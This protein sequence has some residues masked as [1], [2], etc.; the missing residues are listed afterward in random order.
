MSPG[1]APVPAPTD[2]AAT[3]GSF[4]GVDV[5]QQSDDD[6]FRSLLI[7]P[8]GVS[9]DLR[10]LLTKAFALVDTDIDDLLPDNFPAVSASVTSCRASSSGII[11]EAVWSG[12]T[13]NAGVLSPFLSGI[14]SGISVKLAA[15]ASV[16]EAEGVLLAFDL[17]LDNKLTLGANI[18]FGSGAAGFNAGWLSNAPNLGTLLRQAG[19]DAIGFGNV[20]IEKIGVSAL[21]TEDLFS[22]EIE[23]ND[24]FALDNHDFKISDA[25]IALNYLRG[26]DGLLTGSA[27][28]TAFLG[29]A[30]QAGQPDDRI[31]F[32]VSASYDGADVGWTFTGTAQNISVGAVLGKFGV[33]SDSPFNDL[34]VD[35]VSLSFNTVSKDVSFS[36]NGS[37][38]PVANAA[39][40]AEVHLTRQPDGSYQKTFSGKLTAGPAEF[41]LIFDQTGSSTALL[42]VF[43]DSTEQ[44]AGINVRDV[45]AAVAPADIAAALPASPAFRIQDALFAFTRG[46]AGQPGKFLFAID[47]DLSLDL[48]GLANL[49]LI[50]QAV[51]GEKLEAAFEVLVYSEQFDPAPIRSLL[52]AGAPQIPNDQLSGKFQFLTT[53]KFGDFTTQLV[54]GPANDLATALA[55]TSS[56]GQP[57]APAVPA[58]ATL[59]A[60]DN[61]KWA[62]IEK[63]FG[64][65]SVHRAGLSFDA[66][67]NQI[68]VFLEADLSVSGLTLSVEGL[69]GIY[70][71][72]TKTLSFALR[73]LGIDFSRGGLEI[74]GG[75]LNQNG[76]FAGKVVIRTQSFTLSALG[77]VAVVDGQPSIFIYGL[78]NYPLG[79]PA[80]FFVEGLAA[81]FGYNRTFRMPTVDQVRSCPLVSDAMAETAVV[82]RA[83][84]PSDKAAVAKQLELLHDFVPPSVGDYFFAAGIKFSSFKLLHSFLLVGIVAGKRFELDLI[85]VSTYENP[86]VAQPGVPALAHIELNL[87][88]RIAPDEGFAIIQGQL[89]DNSY[90]YNSLVKLS[91]GF[92]FATW[93]AEPPGGS[94]LGPH[95]GDF[96]LTI[97]G[98]HPRFAKPDWY[99]TVPRLGITYQINENIYVK[100]T[101]YFA[102]TPSMLMA[103]A[104]LEAHAEIGAI[105]ATFKAA[106][107]FL[108]GW[109]PYHYDASLSVSIQVHFG[110]DFE[111]GA[112]ISIFGPPFSGI[113]HVHANVVSFTVKWGE[114]S[115][116]GPAP[117]PWSSKNGANDGFLN[118]FLLRDGKP[119]CT[120]RIVDGTI[121]SVRQSDGTDLVIINPGTFRLETSCPIP[122]DT[123]TVVVNG[124]TAASLSGTSF[125]VSPMNVSEA[126]G[127]HTVSLSKT[128]GASLAAN[129][130]VASAV[131]KKFPPALWGKQFLPGDPAS[132]APLVDGQGGIELKPKASIDTGTDVSAL[133][134]NLDFSSPS[135]LSIAAFNTPVTYTVEAPTAIS[136]SLAAAGP[137][138]SNLLAALGLNPVIS[139][140]T[141]LEDALVT[142]PSQV[143]V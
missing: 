27:S 18:D 20:T 138:R 100:G 73:G 40:V 143:N 90:V 86:P 94:A 13:F 42:G 142:E 137:L 45:V 61:V 81:G 46:A 25:D 134:R 110:F 123:G 10:R 50:G 28:A 76:D 116:P 82:P 108:I 37:F 140:S 121:G 23:I 70:H 114:L 11:L 44:G 38:P 74:G 48:S 102:L 24:L 139:V 133:R 93:F 54:L 92:A 66:A 64:P 35:S 39:M 68:G 97:G 41:D 135:I 33:P 111:V 79:G 62:D 32:D 125:G 88:G 72:G 56:P 89:T 83:G 113:A 77:A 12:P 141:G 95:A 6:G 19:L 26:E 105:S 103:G 1:A 107:D 132:P 16:S 126:S 30:P 60:T 57:S 69:G 9:G 98:Y 17:V 67:K 52:P 71:F 128:S 120:A 87:I 136:A 43:H 15:N 53:L 14:G 2:I 55:S 51:A 65:L 47:T 78:L 4:L 122:F 118:K 109:E 3:I 130:L 99:P 112:D 49:P 124:N 131:A 21:P 36:F 104:A 63:H 22:F 85:G 119:I 80:F 7:G 59:P 29:K 115:A 84:D 5:S 117:I 34:Q 127:T 91:G 101:A 106:I 58:T 8:G 75:F 31:Q 129:L 96:V